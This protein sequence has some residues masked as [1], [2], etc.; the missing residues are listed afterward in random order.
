MPDPNYTEQEAQLM[1]DRLWLLDS[2]RE[3][4]LRRTP[5]D[6]V[7]LL[8]WITWDLRALGHLCAE[9]LRDQQAW[10]QLIDADPRRPRPSLCQR[11]KSEEE[12]DG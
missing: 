2:L 7:K 9:C 10:R 8:N 4:F 1:L 3:M 12:Y 5:D 6:G 11:P